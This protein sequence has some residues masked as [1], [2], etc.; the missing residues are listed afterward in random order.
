MAR[1][2][3]LLI[4][5]AVFLT[6]ALAARCEAE[7]AEPTCG[8]V[9]FGSSIST[10]L[11]IFEG[12]EISQEAAPYIESIGN[13]ALEGYFKGGLKRD[14]SGICF[15]PG[16]VKKY[17]VKTEN[18]KMCKTVTLYFGAFEVDAKDYGLFM[19]KKTGAAPSAE[20]D[21]KEIFEKMAGELDKET[22]VGHKV[23]QGRIQSFDEQSHSFYLPA[24]VG[25]WDGKDTLAFLM[26]ANSPDSGPLA[27]E[28]VYVSK[29]A[30]KRYLE[31]CKTY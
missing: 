12:A 8:N 15:L 25:T 17:T 4:T 16:I 29:P 26:V 11:E 18:W 2:T 21:F 22:K 14:D 1:R 3:S 5:T 23:D 28:I 13:Y 30:L 10:V 20:A 27:P 24:L 7:P 6:F 9:P 19:V 31:M